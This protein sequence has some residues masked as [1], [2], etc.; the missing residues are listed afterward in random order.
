MSCAFPSNDPGIVQLRLNSKGEW[1][2]I[3]SLGSNFKDAVSHLRPV[4]VDVI[5]VLQV[6]IPVTPA[7]LPP[8]GGLH[9][10]N[11]GTLAYFWHRDIARLELRFFKWIFGSNCADDFLFSD[12]S[13]GKPASP[14]AITED[15]VLSVSRFRYSFGHSHRLDNTFQFKKH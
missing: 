2:V 14:Q 10:Q 8:A 4:P 15:F 12:M 13:P 7:E 3:P 6:V 9:G 1:L 11:Y 5:F